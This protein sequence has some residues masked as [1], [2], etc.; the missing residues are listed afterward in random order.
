M[1]PSL[2]LYRKLADW[3]AYHHAQEV[4][5]ACG[6]IFVKHEVVIEVDSSLGRRL[7]FFQ[8][9]KLLASFDSDLNAT[10]QFIMAFNEMVY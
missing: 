2:N 7:A 1:N 9:N 8:I 10:L 3:A 5:D 4:Y 6:E